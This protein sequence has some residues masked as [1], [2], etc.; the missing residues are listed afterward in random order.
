MVLQKEVFSGKE[1]PIVQGPYSQVVKVGQ[2]LFT[3]GQIGEDPKADIETQTS[4]ALDRIR[5]LL[6]DVGSSL[7]N[8]VKCTV[9]MTDLDE[10]TKMNE[11]YMKYFKDKPPARTTVGVSRLGKNSRIEID[12]IAIA[13][14]K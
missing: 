11:V 13:P 6:E 10:W 12:A 1:R 2:F 4:Q 5:S 14:E 8:V 9:Y 7:D 3:S